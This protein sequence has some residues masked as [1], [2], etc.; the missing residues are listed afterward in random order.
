MGL[1]K[2]LQGGGFANEG[3]VCWYCYR[4]FT[5]RY[6]HQ[7][8]YESLKTAMGGSQTLHDEFWSLLAIV[9]KKMVDTR[10]H[11]VR[12][13]WQEHGGGLNRSVTTNKS[14]VCQLEQPEDQIWDETSY[15]DKYGDW[16]T[17][18]KNHKKV[19]MDGVTGIY[20]PGPKVWKVR[21]F[22]EA[23]VSLNEEVGHDDNDFEAGMLGIMADE[24]AAM[25]MPARAI[26]EALSL[27]SCFR[28]S[29]ASAASSTGHAGPPA[30]VAASS[31]GLGFGL[32]MEQAD[33]DPSNQRKPKTS[34]TSQGGTPKKARVAHQV[35]GGGLNTASP[36]ESPST[37]KGRPKRDLLEVGSRFVLE[38]HNLGSG[39]EYF[40]TRIA[41]N[42]QRYMARLAKDIQA[43]TEELNGAQRMELLL[44]KKQ[45]EVCTAMFKAFIAFGP[46]SAEF[47]VAFDSNMLYLNSEPAASNPLPAF[48]LRHRH[49]FRADMI[50]D[51]EFLTVINTDTLVENK[52]GAAGS[53]TIIKSQATLLRAR[54]MV[55]C[56][57]EN[58]EDVFRTLFARVSDLRSTLAECVAVQIDHIMNIINAAQVQDWEVLSV[59]L[60][61]L[62]LPG[63]S[64]VKV[65]DKHKP[66]NALVEQAV[67]RM[68]TLRTASES[69]AP[70]ERSVTGAL[71]SLSHSTEDT[72]E[73]D[74]G[75]G[76]ELVECFAQCSNNWKLV[77]QGAKDHLRAELHQ[78]VAKLLRELDKWYGAN[79]QHV[80]QRFLDL[81]GDDKM[82][83]G[84]WVV[85][86]LVSRLSQ[87]RLFLL[88]SACWN[89]AHLMTGLL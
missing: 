19:T 67:K 83:N 75:K 1:Q 76:K 27:D 30:H 10:S 15:V 84:A 50:S 3:K 37:K 20:V 28:S 7:H 64:L 58:P 11:K 21:R 87:H 40:A 52:F 53:E 17:N 62:G 29:S 78:Q 32:T 65:L 80:L 24:V 88:P 81:E 35:Q 63:S 60:S 89:S 8:S 4:V 26:G 56:Q 14:Q 48:F 18:G 49:E 72:T 77:P 82:E 12:I 45:V 6:N 42:H 57:K 43:G 16:R 69:R 71:V 2:T 54:V 31:S 79:L 46:S 51:E 44:C 59:S 41:P 33:Q 86:L 13:S 39:D 74:E 55:A 38:F 68:Q 22:K 36:K 5:G 73:L 61:K 23:K 85:L 25:F 47:A 34:Q 66:S 9:K 70:F